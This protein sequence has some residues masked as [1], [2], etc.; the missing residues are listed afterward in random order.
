[1]DWRYAYASVTGTRH[2]RIGAECQDSCDMRV[3]HTKSGELVFVCV[4]SDGSGS[5]KQP[6]IGSKLACFTI[7][8]GI[9]E[10]FENGF[11][12]YNLSRGMAEGLV[13]DFQD[14]VQRYAINSGLTPRD[15]SCTL[16]AAVLGY[17]NAVFFQV[18]D[19]A[20]VILKKGEQGYMPVFWPGKGEYENSTHFAVDYD[21][22]LKHMKYGLIQGTIS[23]AA[24]FTDSLE[25]IALHYRSMS[26][27]SPFFKP[28]FE[29]TRSAARE[30]S[31]ELMESVAAFLN[32]KRV[33]SRT[34]DD[35]TLI[36]ASRC[37]L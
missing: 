21:S 10:F 15:Y 18:G 13:L 36:I 5:A 4:V 29:S 24:L 34:D 14:E 11:E 23:D 19:G 12:V 17:K 6:Q 27:Y 8:E 2:R 30:C 20:V 22:V 35:K 37:D 7:M 25:R 33:N 31:N 32:S 3:I 16:I 9:K 28:L 26:A 1:M